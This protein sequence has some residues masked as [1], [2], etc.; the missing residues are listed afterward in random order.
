MLGPAGSPG[1]ARPQQLCGLEAESA[2]HSQHQC[3][4]LCGIID[5]P[6]RRKT[7]CGRYSG[8]HDRHPQRAVFHGLRAGRGNRD[9][10]H[11][12]AGHVWSPPP[13]SHW[14]LFA[15]R[16]GSWAEPSAD[17]RLQK[18]VIWRHCDGGWRGWPTAWGWHHCSARHCW[19]PRASSA[20]YNQCFD[21]RFILSNGCIN[22]CWNLCRMRGFQSM[23][24]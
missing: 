23:C 16:W 15:G 17:H 6:L 12:D 3:G 14:L 4:G 24:L 20:R 19:L 10:M 1:G 7:G 22:Q 9:T 21:I 2:Q 8:I 5:S 18:D 13:D 11:S